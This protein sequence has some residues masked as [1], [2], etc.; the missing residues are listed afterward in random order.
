[1]RLTAYVLLLFSISVSLYFVGYTNM[2][3]YCTPENTVNGTYTPSK[4]YGKT[5]DGG[6]LE[7]S[8]VI[9]SA[10]ANFL[11]DGLA[12]GALAIVGAV[13]ANVVSGGAIS[14]LLTGFGAIYVIPILMLL[15][16]LA[17]VVYPLSFIFDASLP[18]FIKGLL[19]TFFGVITVLSS[20]SFVRGG[21]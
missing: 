19:T 14:N 4:C 10:T 5:T 3:T 17:Y 16:V 2:L 13:I 12:W 1:M 11:N 15:A 18:F 21:A 20:L 7:M 9:G 6:S 8:D